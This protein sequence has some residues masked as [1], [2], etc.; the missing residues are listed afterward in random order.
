MEHFSRQHRINRIGKLLLVILFVL[1][2]A[3]G[4][5]KPA[6]GSRLFEQTPNPGQSEGRFSAGRFDRDGPGNKAAAGPSL[7]LQLRG[8]GPVS[9]EL[10]QGQ[11]EADA[12]F[13][14]RAM[15]GALLFKPTE[16]GLDLPV[17]GN[18]G[19]LRSERL[20]IQFVG[21]NPT[22]DILGVGQLPAVVNYYLGNDPS[23]WQVG[24]PTYSGVSYAGLYNGVAL[25]YDGATGALKGTYEVSPGSDPAQIRWRYSG[26]SDLSVDPASGDLIVSFA[27]GRAQLIEK[28]PVA[29]QEQDSQRI[30][31][32]SSYVIDPDG[33]IGFTLGA[34][35]PNLALVIDP[36]LAYSTY[37]GAGGDDFSSDIALDSAGGWCVA[38]TI[39]SI[40]NVGTNDA[41]ASC[42]NPGGSLLFTTVV[43]GDSWDGAADIIFLPGCNLPF[44]DIYIVGTT[45]SSNFATTDGTTQQGNG[46]A[47]VARISPYFASTLVGGSQEELGFGIGTIS[48]DIYIS[49]GSNSADLGNSVTMGVPYPTNSGGRDAFIVQLDSWT[50]AKPHATF[51]GGSDLDC[52]F[53][54]PIAVDATGVY[55]AGDTNSAAPE[56]FPAKN[57]LYPFNGDSTPGWGD[58]VFV[59]KLNVGATSIIYNT[60]L[61][62]SSFEEAYGIAVDSTGSVIVVGT[63]GSA[64]TSGGGGFPLTPSSAVQPVFV[65]GPTGTGNNRDA[66]VTKLGWDGTLLSLQYSTFLGGYGY[67][68][69]HD[70]VVDANDNIY[71]TGYTNAPAFPTSR[72]LPGL[73][74]SAGL[75]DAFVSV[76]TSNGASF[77]YSTHLGG[78]ADD[79]GF[80]IAVDTRCQVYVTGRTASANFP[81]ANPWDGSFNGINDAFVSKISDG[82]PPTIDPL[83]N[84]LTL[85]QGDTWMETISVTIPALPTEVEHVWLAPSGGTSGFVTSISPP[86]GFYFNSGV[87][88]T[89]TFDVGFTGTV[90]CTG[91]EQVFEGKLD[92]WLDE[93]GDDVGAIVASKIVTI[94]VPPC[95]GPCENLN[96][97]LSTGTQNDEPP[98][99]PDPIGTVDPNWTV[100]QAPVAVSGQ[101]F[102][103][104]GPTPPW[105]TSPNANWIDPFNTGGLIQDPSGQYTYQRQ[106]TINTATHTNFTLTLLYAVDNSVQFFLNGNAIQAPPGGVTPLTGP[107]TVNNQGWFVNGLNTLTAVVRNFSG[108]LNNPTGLLIDGTLTAECICAPPPTNMAAWWTLDE[109]IGTTARDIIGGNNGAHINGPA[110]TPG[111][112]AG[113]LSF[114]GVDDHVS[115]PDNASLNFGAGQSFSIDMWLRMDP[116]PDAS[117]TSIIEKRQVFG[118]TVGYT[119][120]AFNGNL[121]FQLADGGIGGVNCGSGPNDP[122]SNYISNIFIA[123]SAWHHVAVTIDRVNHIGS[124]YLDGTHVVG[125]DFNTT[126]QDN[127]S[128][129]NTQPLLIGRHAV[130]ANNP[131]SYY[132]GILD[133]IEVFNRVLTAQEVRAVFI[134]NTSGKCNVHIGDLDGSTASRRFGFVRLWQATSEVTVH[135]SNQQPLANA[136][137]TGIWTAPG[138][139]SFQTSCITNATGRCSVISPWYA[140]WL[141]PTSTFTVTQVIHTTGPYCS[142]RNHDPEADSNGTVITIQRPPP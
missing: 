76:M 53:N 1:A 98:G 34:Y 129:V 77:W 111:R 109:T 79:S 102:S 101:A 9:F 41:A 54:C 64:P 17:V 128:L 121:A 31:V 32:A 22:P 120:F 27:A 19:S 70:V 44:C 140:K 92:V 68:D 48:G 87:E 29:W 46:D 116:N 23:R 28:A 4:D 57:E 11:V 103:V 137:V 113:A 66:Y 97:N 91:V 119:L 24:V 83:Y 69:A 107:I 88:H 56:G 126:T 60:W 104:Q 52:E 117:I 138:Q 30:D 81:T 75:R 13:L 50:L 100:I 65:G 142:T 139:A 89:M 38:M 61:G 43:G 73:A 49:G 45:W 6:A 99:I 62:G 12:R 74:S 59:A 132:D 37:L 90:A 134:A 14:A 84:D 21:S 141:V 15:G 86:N 2:L 72:P 16:L 108:P 63:T 10:N 82:C 123:D 8:Q 115:V 136:Q 51:L 122:C 124:W 125:Q 93:D 96:V 80:G 133:E 42:F 127:G 18:D 39:A 71:V 35:N 33:T 40:V 94:H 58:E 130:I 47:F 25:K 78:A 36:T 114:D 26:A 20:A 7:P 112:V 106:F 55:I 118:N 3:A 135:D 131:N 105:V 85:N 95:P 67:E 110:P 5:L